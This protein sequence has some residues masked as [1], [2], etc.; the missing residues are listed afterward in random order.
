VSGVLL[1]DWAVIALSLFNMIL[2]F[3]LGLTILLTAERRE[4]GVWFVGAGAL[5]GAGFFVSHTVLLGVGWVYFSPAVDFWWRAGMLPLV[6]CPW[7]WYLALLWYAGLW[8][9]EKRDLRQVHL[10]GLAAMTLFGLVLLL[11]AL[12]ED[13]AQQI[14]RLLSLDLGLTGRLLLLYPLYTIGCTGLALHALR[15]PAPAPLSARDAA[16]RKAQPWLV[17]STLILL[18]VSLLVAG[19]LVWIL[20]NSL[21]RGLDDRLVVEILV[22]D[23]AIAGLIA[24]SMLLM[25]QAVVTY[26]IFS[27]RSLP[28]A[29]LR[30]QWGR[31]I[32]LSASYSLVIGGVFALQLPAV[33]G[34]LLTALLMTAFFALLGWRTL[35]E[36]R[37]LLAVLRPFVSGEKMYPA[38]TGTG[39][40][41]INLQA[42]FSALC[43]EVLDC[44]HALLAPAGA[45]RTL[46]RQ[47]LV[48][49]LGLAL[50][51]PAL[52]SP[53][54]AN[55]YLPL[56]EQ[57]GGRYQWGVPL[58]NEAGLTGYLYLGPKAGET[59]YVQ[60]E[61]DL[62]QTACERL[63]DMQASASLSRYLLELQ[64][65]EM[66]ETAILDRRSRRVLHDE[67]LPQVHALI[68]EAQGK[69][70]PAV[71]EGLAALHGQ[72]SDL[73]HSM[74][75]TSSPQFQKVG[76]LAALRQVVEGELVQAFASVEWQIEPQAEACLPALPLLSQEVLYYAAREL[77]R[78][79]ARH[80]QR[81]D[82][83]PLQL[84]I[85]LRL[86]DELELTIHDNGPGLSQDWLAATSTVSGGYGLGLHAAMLAVIGGS[87]ALE[88]QAGLMARLRLPAPS[89]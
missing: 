28:R 61:L 71:L 53:R 82:G 84:S 3:W 24:A 2:L 44:R 20:E 31:V 50:E 40:T 5:T 56:A 79:A 18:A 64:R 66:A 22:I 87:L 10:P 12:L 57:T 54:A 62:A 43:T 70:A 86:E 15:R 13:P 14:P 45:F 81:P 73:L 67:I 17:L 41:E 49:P 19:A 29:G 48:Y 4:W 27:S 52:S 36:R 85:R 11:A 33:Y 83:C 42:P 77:L 8:G 9:Q 25:G 37:D 60:E 55:E 23:A 75:P 38:I 63:V 32:I 59:L 72:L 47:D 30:R 80:A 88:N 1:L 76:V 68:L 74:P 78:N 26:E 69:S 21:R 65:Q 7:L 16:R 35:A 51:P 6:L 58:F 46:L 89:S 39:T 34:L